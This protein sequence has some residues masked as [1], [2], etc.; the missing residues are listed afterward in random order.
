MENQLLLIILV[1]SILLSGIIFIF[2][3]KIKIL[4]SELTKK[5]SKAAQ[6]ARNAT[7]GDV[8]QILG[9]FAI[10]SNFDELITLSTTSRQPSL[11]ILGVL[12][13]EMKIVFIEFK[14]KGASVSSK[15]NKLR[16]IIES[17]N[18]EY[19]VIDVTLP[20]LCEIEE[21]KLPKI[22]TNVS[23]DGNA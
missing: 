7:L 22:R 2:L 19:K 5:Q 8:H 21:R 9:E 12:W 6:M 15:E 10:L 23:R 3:R 14:K 11:D 18:V 13:K 16:R 20:P 17:K 1:F 4:G